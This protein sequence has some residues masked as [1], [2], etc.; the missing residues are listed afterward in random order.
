V[1]RTT[2]AEAIAFNLVFSDVTY[3]GGTPV[4]E[5]AAWLLGLLAIPAL[6][7]LC[8]RRKQVAIRIPKS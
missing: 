5:P 7:Y 6:V 2:T 8:N 3:T 1:Q 4:P